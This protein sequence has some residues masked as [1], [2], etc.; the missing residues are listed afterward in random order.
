MGYISSRTR[1]PGEILEK[2]SVPFG[3][4]IFN[5]ILMK[6]GH[7]VYLYEISDELKNGYVQSKTR[8][9]GQI[10]EEYMLVTK[11]LSFKSLLFNAIP[12]NTQGSGE[13]LQ[14][15]SWPSC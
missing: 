9:Q 5:L 1:S 10:I 11:G 14:G 4:Y 2:S 7:S 6:L 8:S 15:L 13:R 12:H 3:G